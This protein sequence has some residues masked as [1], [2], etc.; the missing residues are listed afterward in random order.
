VLVASARMKGTPREEI[1]A[2]ISSALRER[3]T[4]REQFIEVP[5]NV[6]ATLSYP[7]WAAVQCENSNERQHHAVGTAEAYLLQKKTQRNK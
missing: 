4:I 3:P 1:A 2:T 5:S 6:E 7:P